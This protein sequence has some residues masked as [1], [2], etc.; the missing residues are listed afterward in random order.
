MFSGEKSISRRYRIPSQEQVVAE[1][2][3]HVLD[4]KINEGWSVSINR[5]RV[6]FVRAISESGLLFFSFIII[7]VMKQWRLLQP[8]STSIDRYVFPAVE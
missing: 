4:S 8:I 7:I 1:E 3:E 2:D 6:D 5:K